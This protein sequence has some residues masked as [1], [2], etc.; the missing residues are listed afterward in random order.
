MK[1]NLDHI[2]ETNWDMKTNE[3]MCD[4][5]YES[6]CTAMIWRF[7]IHD[8]RYVVK[9]NCHNTIN[10]KCLLHKYSIWWSYEHNK[11]WYSSLLKSLNM[12]LDQSEWFWQ[13]SNWSLDLPSW[14][15]SQICLWVTQIFL[16]CFLRQ[17]NTRRI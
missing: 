3:M 1:K 16:M 9:A 15:S 13:S 4:E 14:K 17:W 7:N 5:N 8:K 11:R 2:D 10:L 6:H 12:R